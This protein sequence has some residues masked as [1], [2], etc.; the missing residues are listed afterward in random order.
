M[1]LSKLLNTPVTEL[2][3]A[4]RIEAARPSTSKKRKV[5]VDTPEPT[6]TMK[7]IRDYGRYVS[8]FLSLNSAVDLLPIFAVG[9]HNTMKEI[10]ESWAM[11]QAV[12]DHVRGDTKKGK[13]RVVVVGDGATARTG[14][15][16]A[17]MTKWAVVSIDPAFRPDPTVGIRVDRLQTFKSRIEDM[18]ITEYEEDVIIVM[19]HS[20]ANANTVLDRI[21]SKRQRSL[22]VCPCCLPGTQLPSAKS[23][24][25]QYNDYN[26]MT[27]QNLVY[28]YKKI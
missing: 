21:R 2:M 8:H 20:H 4:K 9:Q 11:Y 14:A 12:L 15:L 17:Y 28:V 18:P 7:Q 26:M 1:N 5:S 10:A 24:N 3:S 16:F 23:P 22:I 13:V 19:P 6:M 27:E 25:V